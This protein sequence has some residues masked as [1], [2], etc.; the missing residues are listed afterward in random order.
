MGYPYWPASDLFLIFYPFTVF[1]TYI[2]RCPAKTRKKIR[3]NLNYRLTGGTIV[4]SSP[5][6]DIHHVFT[7]SKA[8]QPPF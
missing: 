7:V 6:L 1:G 5:E 8:Q 4:K 2:Q 3:A